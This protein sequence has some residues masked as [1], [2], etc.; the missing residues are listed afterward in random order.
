MLVNGPSKSQIKPNSHII[1]E[2]AKFAPPSGFCPTGCGLV[3]LTIDNK[4]PVCNAVFKRGLTWDSAV[5]R[6]N[7]IC[8]QNRSILDTSLYEQVLQVK[9]PIM[10]GR[11]FYSVPFEYIVEFDNILNHT[12]HPEFFQKV[13]SKCKILRN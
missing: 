1:H 10:I 6:F 4:C 12:R 13:I 8:E 5:K 9:M 11:Y 7:E 3:Q 2:K